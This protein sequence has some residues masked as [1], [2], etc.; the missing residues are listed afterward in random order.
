MPIYIFQAIPEEAF[1]IIQQ[2]G[3]KLSKNNVTIQFARWNLIDDSIVF[4]KS[5]TDDAT[6][7]RLYGCS[8]RSDGKQ[9]IVNRADHRGRNYWYENALIDTETFKYIDLEYMET[10]YDIPAYFI[11]REY[12]PPS[13]SFE[14][15][16]YRRRSANVKHPDPS[17]LALQTG[18]KTINNYKFQNNAELEFIDDMINKRKIT[19]KK[20]S[21]PFSI[22][23]EDYEGKKSSIDLSQLPG[24]Y[25]L[26]KMN[27]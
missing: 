24:F 19:V 27:V 9:I 22:F 10:S 4:D 3:S 11:D 12:N 13:G 20:K 8:L 21:H 7:L 6:T 5:V 17:Y 18:D 15:I 23:F 1:I 2:K 25:K 16:F 26:E 14:C